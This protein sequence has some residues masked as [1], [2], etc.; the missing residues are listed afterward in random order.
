MKGETANP[1]KMGVTNLA[2]WNDA[3]PDHVY[4]EGGPTGKICP[5][6][7]SGPT[8][9]R[10]VV[11]YHLSGQQEENYLPIEVDTLSAQGTLETAT[12]QVSIDYSGTTT[13]I[14]SNRV[15]DHAVDSIYAS[16]ASTDANSITLQSAPLVGSADFVVK[17]EAPSRLIFE[18]PNGGKYTVNG[19]DQSPTLRLVQGQTYTFQNNSHG[20]HPLLIQKSTDGGTT[21]ATVSGNSVTFDFIAPLV[22]SSAQYRYECGEFILG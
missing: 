13:T 7:P 17:T 6:T 18:S 4:V 16:V 12:N 1:I 8:P 11:Q 5:D 3:V 10:L 2:T 19:I 14:Y 20:S 22:D 9:Y 21:F 15:P